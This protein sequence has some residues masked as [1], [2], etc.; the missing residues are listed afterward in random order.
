MAVVSFNL[1]SAGYGGLLGK[2]AKAEYETP[3]VEPLNLEPLKL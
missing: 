3:S 2:N 1:I